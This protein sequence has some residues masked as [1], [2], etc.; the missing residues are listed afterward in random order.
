[1]STA[2]TARPRAAAESEIARHSGQLKLRETSPNHRPPCCCCCCCRGRLYGRAAYAL[3][4]NVRWRRCGPLRLLLRF[5]LLLPEPRPRC[6]S[7]PLRCP[8]PA[9]A[10][11][12]AVVGLRCRLCGWWKGQRHGIDVP[13]PKCCC[14]CCSSSTCCC[15]CCTCSSGSPA[16]GKP[17]AA[18][19]DASRCGTAAALAAAA[20]PAA[21]AE[22][23]KPLRAANAALPYSDRKGE[24]QFSKYSRCCVSLL[25]L[26]LLLLSLMLLLLLLLPPSRCGTPGRV[27]KAGS[28]GPVNAAVIS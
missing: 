7:L 28:G 8:T 19:R 3:Q 18:A 9:A 4:P 11:A 20:P 23:K 17:A 5:L 21:M 2:C 22:F 15:C 6:R 27:W 13:R 12:A 14:C 10:A 25:L 24:L 1:M 26:L 16:P